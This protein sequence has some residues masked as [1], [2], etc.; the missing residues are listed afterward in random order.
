MAFPAILGA[1]AKTGVASGLASG[2]S[3]LVSG[4]FGRSSSSKRRA[5]EAREDSRYQ[6]SVKDAKAAGLHPLFALG[7]GGSGSPG[8][9]ISGQSES[10]SVDKDVMRAMLK[11]SEPTKTATDP[12]GLVQAQTALAAVELARHSLSND[13][14][15]TITIPRHQPMGQE[16]RLGQTDAHMTKNREQSL[17]VKS[18]MTS[19]RIGS[20]NVWLPVE[21]LETA[22]EDPLAVLTSAYSYHG[23]KNVDF[24]KL[25]LEYSGKLGIFEYM[26][27]NIK[28]HIPVKVRKRHLLKKYAKPAQ[29]GAMP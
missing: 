26:A 3:G 29:Y 21:D 1:A 25:A 6:R 15:Q 2:L 5:A 27:K 4:L 9:S 23:N 10:G 14:A 16:V 13:G 18:P 12:T 19:F 11:S 22:M 28:K 7:A 17:N 20:Q 24:Y 8:F